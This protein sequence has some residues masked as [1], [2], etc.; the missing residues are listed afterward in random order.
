MDAD[1]SQIVLRVLAAIADDEAMKNAFLSGADIH[2][3]TA[4]QVLKIPASEVT[5]EQ[6]A[7][8]KAV[9]FGIVYGIGE[10]SLSKDL[11]ISVS[12]ARNYITGYLEHYSGVKAYMERAKKDAKELGYVKTMSLN[13]AI[14]TPACLE[15]ESHSTPPS[16]AVRQIL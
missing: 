13:R 16:R 10:Y 3:E 9:N 12:E 5:K 7:S 2:T 4:A 6:R 1:Y 15:K 14:T 8:A 11:K